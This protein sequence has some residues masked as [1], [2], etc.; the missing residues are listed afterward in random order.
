MDAKY[1]SIKMFVGDGGGWYTH[2][3]KHFHTIRKLLS[4]LWHFQ[5]QTLNVWIFFKLGVFSL[6]RRKEPLIE[7]SEMKQCKEA[8]YKNLTYEHKTSNRQWKTK[9]RGAVL[10]YNCLSLTTD[11]FFY[12]PVFTLLVRRRIWKALKAVTKD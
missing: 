10:L 2:G 9:T 11:L 6:F 7:Q 8:C 12:F 3:R 5:S 4:S 1:N